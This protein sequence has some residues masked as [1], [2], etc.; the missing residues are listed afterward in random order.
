MKNVNY[1]RNIISCII[2]QPSYFSMSQLILFIRR[3][4]IYIWA[5]SFARL[6]NKLQCITHF[7]QDLVLR[8]DNFCL[9]WCMLELSKQE[10]FLDLIC[11]AVCSFIAINGYHGTAHYPKLFAFSYRL[12]SAMADLLWGDAIPAIQILFL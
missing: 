2:F 10:L 5:L 6:I 3:N 9:R 12:G 8:N 11:R 4:L 7:I 1:I